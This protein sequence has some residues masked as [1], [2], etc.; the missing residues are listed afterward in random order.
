MGRIAI[1]CTATPVVSHIAALEKAIGV[2]VVSSS[3]AM[4]WDAL[5]LAGYRK[6]IQGYGRLLEARRQ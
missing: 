3:Q 4:A 5:R 2:P 1:S 6:P